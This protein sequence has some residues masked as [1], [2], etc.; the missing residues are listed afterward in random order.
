M[1]K[2]LGN[3]IKKLRKQSNLNQAQLARILNVSPAL[4]SAYELGDRK[5]SLELLVSLAATF[6]VSTDYLLGLPSPPTFCSLEGL[7]PMEAQAILV[8]VQSLR[9]DNRNDTKTVG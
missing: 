7:S 2:E 1:D 6:K 8:I 9:N 4:I 3:R 5:P